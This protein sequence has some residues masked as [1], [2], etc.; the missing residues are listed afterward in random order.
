MN[1]LVIPLVV[2]A[3][4]FT[5]GS[6][7]TSYV[8][9]AN[10]TREALASSEQHRD[11][12]TKHAATVQESLSD[13]GIKLKM[14]TS[15]SL[16]ARTDLNRLQHNI[17]TFELPDTDTCSIERARITSLSFLLSEGASLVEESSGHVEQL[18]ITNQSLIGVSP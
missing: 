18:R 11:G 5:A 8:Y 15:S 4:G 2:A 10:A 13:Y 7:V 6:F 16:V 12:E 3:I 9:K 1:T 14:E 17:K